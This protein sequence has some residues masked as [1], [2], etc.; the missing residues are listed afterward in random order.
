MRSALTG[1]TARRRA[2]VAIA[3]VT[4]PWMA[5]SPAQADTSPRP[6]TDEAAV[7]W[8]TDL[9][10]STV[11]GAVVRVPGCPD[12]AR[13]GLRVDTTNRGTSGTT[14]G[15][16]VDEQV[17]LDLS[18]LDLGIEPV[19]GVTVLLYGGPTGPVEMPGSGPGA[20]RP[21]GA[22][23]DDALPGAGTEIGPGLVAAAVAALLGG[24]SLL[25]AAR[26]RRSSART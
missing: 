17:A 9:T 5:V 22:T 18:G 1:R 2:M 16:V 12:G 13:V 19:T 20:D 25:A 11:T 26:R 24:S 7:A 21:A 3:T 15:S 8:Q 23:A 6:C 14:T 4:A 10:A